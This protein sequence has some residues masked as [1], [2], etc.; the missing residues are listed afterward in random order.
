LD[1]T[2]RIFSLIAK[3][4]SKRVAKKKIIHFL[5]RKG[6][7]EP[8]IIEAYQQF[9][10]KEK[11]YEITFTE[12]PLGFSVIMDTRGNNAIVSSIQT[13][14]N[15]ELGLKIASRMYEVNGKR[16]D[17]LKHKQ[18]LSIIASCE[19]PFFIV[20]KES[21]KRSVKL[22]KLSK[23]VLA[24]SGER[25][26][27]SDAWQEDEEESESEEEEDESSYE[28][29]YSEDS[30]SGY[31]SSD[32]V[33]HIEKHLERK[34]EHE[35]K[36]KRR[37]LR[38][39]L[40]KQKGGVF[41]P[42]EINEWDQE[43]IEDEGAEMMKELAKLMMVN[44]MTAADPDRLTEDIAT[45]GMSSKRAGTLRGL[46][47]ATPK[48]L[49]S[50]MD[51]DGEKEHSR[52]MSFSVTDLMAAEQD[53]G[54]YDPE[55]IGYLQDLAGEDWTMPTGASHAITPSM[56][57]MMHGFWGDEDAF[58]EDAPTMTLP[59]FGL[60]SSA[61]E[62][63]KTHVDTPAMM[64]DGS[65]IP[66][67]PYGEA[68]PGLDDVE[69]P[70]G[71]ASASTE[72]TTAST[73]D[74]AEVGDEKDTEE[75][76]SGESVLDKMKGG[77]TFMKYGRFGRPKYRM[78]QLSK[79]HK[80]LL[81]F[82][83]RK[84]QSDT[85]IPIKYI[86]KIKIGKESDAS[87]KTKSAEVQETSFTVVYGKTPKSTSSL[88]V[89]AKNEKEAFVWAQGLKMLA[90]H[91]RKGKDLSKLTD[92]E[93]EEVPESADDVK[94]R[95]ARSGSVVIDMDRMRSASVMSMFSK[96]DT[97][98]VSALRK[99]HQSLKAQL[100]K[101]VD[102]VMTK[103]NYRIIKEKKEFE[104]VKATLESIDIRLRDIKETLSGKSEATDVTTAKSDLFS[105]HADLDAL[106]HKLTVLV[107]QQKRL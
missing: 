27:S 47:S 105:I 38:K 94:E 64:G 85:R 82:S 57:T 22:E 87:S 28:S 66:M 104:S 73:G 90:D 95:H 107:R 81:W 11:L 103:S 10:E 77:T 44:A 75:T 65:E 84:D 68:M 53:D 55:I 9:Y 100:Q 43:V 63:A 39:K 1:S 96:A 23:K 89:T 19:C 46:V 36:K 80:Y 74:G 13:D 48:A 78:F 72:A 91:S 14:Q 62:T 16:V 8:K 20:F 69:L 51:E 30:E 4:E 45:S 52:S 71:Y 59:T 21:A 31:S 99:K 34:L 79:D 33:K 24:E 58:A 41:K 3:A 2:E 35:R 37:A 101:C 97:A 42:G 56:S 102:F 6:V 40:K 54:G 70:A 18:I 86:Q 93:L 15:D 29:G 32:D 12:R 67:I 98:T 50:M 49:G 76:G 26:A 25:K 60:E 88:T 17:G 83:P 7:S 92:L 61:A 5:K 106:R